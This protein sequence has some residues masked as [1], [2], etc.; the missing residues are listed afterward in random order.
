MNWLED[1]L[2]ASAHAGKRLAESVH[3]YGARSKKHPRPESDLQ[4]SVCPNGLSGHYWPS[5]VR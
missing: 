5:S 2:Y 3:L 4:Q 1:A